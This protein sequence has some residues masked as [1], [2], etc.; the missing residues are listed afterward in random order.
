MAEYLEFLPE[1]ARSALLMP[2]PAE[3]PFIILSAANATEAE[4][5]E[6]DSWVRQSPRGRHIRIEKS[7]HWLQLEKPEIVVGVIQELVQQAKDQKSAPAV[8]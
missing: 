6:R 2:I 8:S 1:S 5:E 4:L 3:I 7:G